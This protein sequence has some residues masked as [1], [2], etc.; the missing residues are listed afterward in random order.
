MLRSIEPDDAGLS[1]RL[2]PG[3][4]KTMGRAPRADFVVDAA[5]VSRLHCRFTLS[6][7]NELA[8]EDL[9]STNG[10]FVNGRK[11][12]ARTLLNDGDTLTVGRVKFV[13]NAEATAAHDSPKVTTAD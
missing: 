10:T 12:M 7:A 3:T 9:G 8:L 1:F 11:V 5:L 2:M 6:D 4:L 13:V